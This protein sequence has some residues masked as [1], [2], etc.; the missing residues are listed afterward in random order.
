M[1][2]VCICIYCLL[3]PLHRFDVL[4]LFLLFTLF[5]SNFTL[6]YSAEEV[7]MFNYNLCNF[8]ECI[9]VKADKNVLKSIKMKG[10]HQRKSKMFS[11]AMFF[12]SSDSLFFFDAA[13][14]ATASDSHS[15]CLFHV[16]MK[17]MCSPTFVLTRSLFTVYLSTACSLAFECKIHYHLMF[18]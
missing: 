9:E 16:C 12:F 18:F 11:Y 6:L 13:A 10:S 2:A 7:S 3:F 17:S 1:F 5:F 4:F 15:V 14:L 8:N